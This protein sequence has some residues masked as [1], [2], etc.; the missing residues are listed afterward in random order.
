MSRIVKATFYS[1][2]L[3]RVTH[4][5]ASLS[6]EVAMACLAGSDGQ[7]FVLNIYWPAAGPFHDGKK[8]KC[9]TTVSIR[10][11]NNLPDSCSF[12]ER[13]LKNELDNNLLHPG[14]PIQAT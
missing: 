12:G 4:G 5:V 6:D 1:C 7:A 11:L 14:R 10:P 13:P 2:G 3:A 9:Y 8:G